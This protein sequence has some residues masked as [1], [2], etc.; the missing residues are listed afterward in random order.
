M[1]AT[2]VDPGAITRCACGEPASANGRECASCFR[3][4]L[5]S[6]NS[7]FT[8]TRSAGAGQIDP[9]KS[10]RWDH[11]LEDYRKVRKE[12][13]QPK[14]TKRRDIEA[15]KRASDQIGAPIRVGRSAS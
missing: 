7:G 2:L 12:G 15:T 4:R 9:V 13:S 6:V 5:A 11:R 14:S 8:P 10:H 3:D 1:S